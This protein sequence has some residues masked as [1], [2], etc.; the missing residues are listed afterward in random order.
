MAEQGPPNR[1]V[2]LSMRILPQDL[3]LIE[4]LAALEER[5]VSQIARRLIRYQLSRLMAG[6]AK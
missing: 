6:D 2:L 5:S 4:Q 3:R 1:L